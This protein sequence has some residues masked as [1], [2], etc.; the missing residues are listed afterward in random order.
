MQR[1]I[2][3]DDVPILEAVQSRPIS[4]GETAHRAIER[5]APFLKMCRARGLPIIYT[6]IVPE[7]FA[8]NDSLLAIVDPIE[9]DTD[10]LVIDKNYPS[11]FYGTPLLTHL[12]RQGIDTTIIV[13]NTTSGC[14]RATAVDARQFGF[15]VVVV[16][17]CV[18]DRIA[19][20]HKIGLLDMW[21][22]YAAV[23]PAA[24]VDAYVHRIMELNHP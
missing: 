14:V 3:N 1:L 7:G 13:G 23:L 21:M 6:R 22:K 12:V 2:V 9:P 18:F 4:I 20:S 15:H 17:D 10:D 24:D 8:A 5:I 11:S 19:A 16:E